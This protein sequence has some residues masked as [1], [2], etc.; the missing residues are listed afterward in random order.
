M[1]GIA[2][3]YADVWGQIAGRNGPSYAPPFRL[4]FDGDECYLRGTHRAG[5]EC[6]VKF[7]EV[8]FRP[9]DLPADAV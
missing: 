8:L 9:I 4:F 7:V 2:E 6:S 3:R 1:D 5:F